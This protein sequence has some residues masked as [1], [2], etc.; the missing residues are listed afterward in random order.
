MSP[1][2]SAARIARICEGGLGDMKD[3]ADGLCNLVDQTRL[4]TIVGSSDTASSPRDNTTD[5]YQLARET[6]RF[7]HRP[8]KVRYRTPQ[9]PFENFR[10]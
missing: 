7:A 6:D 3:S 1:L 5:V 2:D 10:G 9:R 8:V 4:L